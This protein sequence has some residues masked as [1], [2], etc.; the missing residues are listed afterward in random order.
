MNYCHTKQ[1]ENKMKQKSVVEKS[2]KYFDHDKTQLKVKI[3]RFFQMQKLFFL[4]KEAGWSYQLRQIPR[5]KN[6]KYI[7]LRFPKT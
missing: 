6:V 5:K 1:E 3:G 4:K 7:F 2:S